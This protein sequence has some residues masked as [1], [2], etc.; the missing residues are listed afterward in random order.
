MAKKLFTTAVT[1][2]GG[3]EGTAVSKDGNFNM[4]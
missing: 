2:T 1:V 4:A 3:R